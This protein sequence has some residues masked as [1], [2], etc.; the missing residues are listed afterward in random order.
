MV[1]T[2]QKTGFL[3]LKLYTVSRNITGQKTDEISG[4]R[5]RYELLSNGPFRDKSAAMECHII[6]PDAMGIDRFPV[7]LA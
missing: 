2:G 4:S 5:I 3:G 6:Q 1:N 7:K